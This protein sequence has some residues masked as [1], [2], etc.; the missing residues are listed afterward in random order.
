MFAIFEVT[1]KEKMRNFTNILSYIFFSSF[2]SSHFLNLFFFLCQANHYLFA[3]ISPPICTPE[4]ER[5]TAVFC[6]KNIYRKATIFV[7]AF[8]L[9]NY[10]MFFFFFFHAGLSL[11]IVVQ[12]ELWKRKGKESENAI[13]CSG[14]AQW[15]LIKRYYDYI[16]SC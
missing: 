5:A 13:K 12:Q 9:C 7:L 11:K 8:Y 15:A 6:S 16:F 10:F 14:F 4:T 2:L 1:N 3:V